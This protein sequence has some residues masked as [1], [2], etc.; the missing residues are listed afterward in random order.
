[1]HVEINEKNIDRYNMAELT[2]NTREFLLSQAA[3]AAASGTVL[4]CKVPDDQAAAFNV[5]EEFE[6]EH[7]DPRRLRGCGY[8]E[9]ED[10]DG[11]K[12]LVCVLHGKTSHHD[13]KADPHAPCLQVDPVARPTQEQLN[14]GLKAL[15]KTCV[16]NKLEDPVE[17][18]VYLCAVHGQ[19]SKYDVTRLP[20]M[21]CLLIEPR[22][23]DE[24][25]PHR[26]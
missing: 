5:F 2:G 14:E 13:L 4:S 1:M 21:P 3:D 8:E 19:P 9:K 11:N 25:D 12:H 10:V 6:S 18:T 26:P 7:V 15:T 22:R 17:G 20:N 24:G 16:Y 23:L